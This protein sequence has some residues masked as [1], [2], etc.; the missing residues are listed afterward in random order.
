MNSLTTDHPAFAWFALAALFAVGGWA[1]MR[2]ASHFM[3]ENRAIDLDMAARDA[4]AG[5]V[6]RQ[7]A[8][9]LTES[10]HRS[11]LMT[12]LKDAMRNP[13]RRCDIRGVPALWAL[14]PAQKAVWLAWLRGKEVVWNGLH[15]T[16]TVERHEHLTLVRFT[17]QER[18]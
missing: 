1:M 7:Q 13:M 16:A 9:L 5:H 4:L 17:S 10:E 11:L 18:A 3:K 14:S 8:R 15:L 6:A 2:L 12:V